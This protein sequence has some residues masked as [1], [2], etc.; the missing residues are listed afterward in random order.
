M[1]CVA[2]A[3]RKII[4][5]LQ[6]NLSC[7]YENIMTKKKSFIKRFLKITGIVLAS[8]IVLA[9]LAYLFIYL[10]MHSRLNKQYAFHK[11]DIMI[12]K[13]S[14]SVANGSHLVVIRGCVDCHGANFGGKIMNDDAMLGRIAA[15]NLTHGNGGLPAGY[16]NADWLLALRHGVNIQGKPLVFMP[17]HETT[18]FS[19]NDVNDIIAYIQQLPPV[20]NTLPE[21][22]IGPV[23][24]VMSY[25]D[26][27]PLLSVEKID[28]S[29]AMERTK[30]VAGSIEQGKYLSITCKSCH[31]DNMKGGEP[32]AP[33]LLP[34]PD[35]TSTGAA[36]RITL[37]QFTKALR[38]GVKENGVQMSNDNMPWKMTSHY[39]DDEVQALY[40]YLKSL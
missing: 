14:A 5:S 37:Q 17:S 36:G 39:S 11:D 15:P 28:H 26:K 33:G 2:V 34:V 31:R 19:K 1:F 9:L 3:E 16:T 20:N 40:N 32:L 29:K 18:L 22:R 23:I 30:F 35:L 10:D 7:S 12:I 4:N 25:L 6:K 13:D 27:F 8:L 38:T 24:Y 21:N